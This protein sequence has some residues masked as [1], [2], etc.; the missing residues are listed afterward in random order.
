MTALNKATDIPSDIVTVEQLAVWC[1]VT[2]TTINPTLDAVEGQNYAVRAAQ[3][4][5][6][7]IAATNKDRFVGRQS[8]ELEANYRTGSK[9]DWMYAKELSNTPL[10]AE[11]KSN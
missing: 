4:G 1:A 9:K 5:V 11:M 6:Y 2:L 7:N 10:T 3:A 8:I